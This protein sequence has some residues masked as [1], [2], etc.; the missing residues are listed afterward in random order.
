[1][2]DYALN[3]AVFRGE[4]ASPLLS[5]LWRN[6]KARRAVVRLE[7]LDDH[8]LRDIGVSRGEVQWASR[9]PLT[10][11]AALALEERGRLRRHGRVGD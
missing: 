8:L 2:R 1:M 11:N 5:R 7:N 10:V 6:W 9:L 3:E 4:I